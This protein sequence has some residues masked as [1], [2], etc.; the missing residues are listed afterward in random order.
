M[1][2]HSE[3]Y[4]YS[5]F[6]DISSVGGAAG[7]YALPQQEPHT[8]EPRK[9]VV[10]LPGRRPQG[11][12]EKQKRPKRSILKMALAA[13]YFTVVFGASIAVVFSQ[14]QLTEITE[15]INSTKSELSEAQSVEVQL[16]MQAAQ[17]MSDAEVE[18]YAIE[19]L[20]MGKLSGSQVVYLHV[21]QQDRGTVVQE[22]GEGSW[23]DRVI[24][25]VRGWFA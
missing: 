14:V 22:T 11:E 13:A 16:T 17:K 1:A 24:A 15:A 2:N 8:E 5:Y 9:K 23:L 7:A 19:E 20:G 10:E 18:R 3:A 21:A 12:P 6:E 4:D 25:A